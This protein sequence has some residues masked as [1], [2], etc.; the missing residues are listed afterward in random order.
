[1]GVILAAVALSFAASAGAYGL[2][3]FGKL[4]DGNYGFVNK[5]TREV[6]SEYTPQE[7][8]EIDRRIGDAGIDAGATGQAG[9]TVIE[10]SSY[11]DEHAAQKMVEDLR[12]GKPYAT[13]GEAEVGD[14]LAGVGESEGSLPG[15][16][17]IAASLGDGIAVAGTAYLGVQIGTAIDEVF[18]L[19]TLFGGPGGSLK[20]GRG[21]WS[22]K[23]GFLNGVELQHVAGPRECENFSESHY[24]F[25]LS[26][27]GYCIGVGERY[28]EDEWFESSGGA[29]EAFH[30]F[31]AGVPWIATADKPGGVT[32]EGNKLCGG[33]G[34][35]IAGLE[36][37][38]KQVAKVFKVVPE[39]DWL[40]KGTCGQWA[41]CRVA[42]PQKLPLP[43]KTFIEMVPRE[44]TKP[45]AVPEK[46]PPD[47]TKVPEVLP[48]YVV[49]ESPDIEPVTGR[50]P[51][52]PEYPE[53]PEPETDEL[54]TKYREDVERR[55]FT[56][57]KINTLPDTAI[58]PRVGP[59]EV[60]KVS[61]APGSKV[62]P[63]TEVVVDA[64]PEDAPQPQETL[65]GVTPPTIPG[66][67]LPHVPTPCNVF[68]FGA[69]CWLKSQFD[70]LAATS[71][72]PK[73]SVS[74]PFGGELTVDA[75]VAEPL[76]EVLRPAL[77]FVGFV[78]LMWM[79]VGAAKTGGGGDGS[80]GGGGGE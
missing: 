55:G 47:S 63:A 77:V 49:T 66:I 25:H 6:L 58:D 23:R 57:V 53:I 17:D 22:D 16:A 74:T 8:L 35:C 9:N 51:V 37:E 41:A 59:S 73:F 13:Q 64:N 29:I 14:A 12:T 5:D 26:G 24:A 36:P 32:V 45:P 38:H 79:V 48:A 21:H 34:F 44:V 7:K 56:V 27:G 20:A 52:A 71:E 69:P 18:G 50:K 2:Y 61:P 62:A 46:A 4:G 33:N 30:T 3:E 80:A 11:A 68:P 60:S 19:P 15:L 43:E 70:A 42:F 67:V 1:M 76:M 31:E 72:A 65:V 78:G 75:L 54:A 40:R 10:G 39:R 28:E